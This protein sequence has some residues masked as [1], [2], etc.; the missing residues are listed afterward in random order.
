MAPMD[1]SPVAQGRDQPQGDRHVDRRP[2]QED[3][4]RA[5][6]TPAPPVVDTTP[7]RRSPATH[8]RH[9]INR[10]SRSRD[11]RPDES[12]QLGRDLTHRR[13]RASP[14]T[15]LVEAVTGYLIQGYLASQVQGRPGLRATHPPH[16]RLYPKERCEHWTRRSKRSEH[17]QP[18]AHYPR[19]WCRRVLCTPHSP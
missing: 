5:R 10:S 13:W 12:W 14:G 6:H 7:C 8:C 9:A 1:N 17:G 18:L 11:F 19:H 3:A 2:P 16:P 4:D 15:P